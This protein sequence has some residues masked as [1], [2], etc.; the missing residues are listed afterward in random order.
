MEDMR[1]HA[2]QRPAASVPCGVFAAYCVLPGAVRRKGCSPL[3]MRRCRRS[4][5]LLQ[6][7]LTLMRNVL[8]AGIGGMLLGE[9]YRRWLAPNTCQ[10]P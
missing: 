5:P 7:A 4:A 6:V 9:L 3:M 10:A 2:G 8:I 1:P